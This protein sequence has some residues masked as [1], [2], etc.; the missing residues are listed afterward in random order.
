MTLR[1]STTPT[2]EALSSR[3]ERCRRSLLRL[4]LRPQAV[5]SVI[6]WRPPSHHFRGGE[7]TLWSR[8]LGKGSD[9]RSSRLGLTTRSICHTM[10]RRPTHF[11]V[12]FR[13]KPSQTSLKT[14]KIRVKP[15]P[16]RRLFMKSLRSM[17]VERM[18]TE[19]TPLRVRAQEGRPEVG[20][21]ARPLPH[22]RRQQKRRS[23]WVLPL[24]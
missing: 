24:P 4:H 17:K 14:A 5:K 21:I 3:P 13:I 7:K 9:R 10:R 22:S 15:R 20:S 23:D 18:A 16:E 8:L 19:V 12:N 1:E 11:W 6:R 2:T